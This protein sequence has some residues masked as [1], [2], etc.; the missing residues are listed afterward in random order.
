MN[1]ELL[2]PQPK[3]T[4]SSS[5]Q[6][7]ST[8][9]NDTEEQDTSVDRIYDFSD[10]DIKPVKDAD[11]PITHNVNIQIAEALRNPA[12]T[13]QKITQQNIEEESDKSVSAQTQRQPISPPE[14]I[15]NISTI[16]NQTHL[17]PVTNISQAINSNNDNSIT[18]KQPINKLEEAPSKP[19]PHQKID[20][21]MQAPAVKVYSQISHDSTTQ[22]QTIQANSVLKSE[23]IQSKAPLN[24]IKKQQPATE[25]KTPTSQPVVDTPIHDILKR[26]YNRAQKTTP[27][28]KDEMLDKNIG[29]F[30][31]TPFAPPISD[32]QTNALKTTPNIASVQSPISQTTARID[33]YREPINSETSP[34]GPNTINDPQNKTVNNKP[35][36]VPSNPKTKTIGNSLSD[37]TDTQFSLNTPHK[38]LQDALS[39]VLPT[40]ATSQGDKIEKT[41]Q[42]IYQQN[43]NKTGTSTILKPIRTFEG[44]VAE[45]MSHLHTSTA[46]VAIAENRRKSG[47]DRIDN[48]SSEK[49]TQPSNIFSKI[50]M[51]ITGILLIGGGAYVG[52]RFYI[53][54]PLA[55]TTQQPTQRQNDGII[56]SDSRAIIAIDG[57]IPIT[58][59]S[60]IIEEMDRE[61]APK[62]IK[63]II[64]AK[65]IGDSYIGITSSEALNVMDITAPDII[66]RTLTPEWMLG[67]YKN[68]DGQTD[69]FIIVNTT[70]F[71]NAFAGMLQWE[72]VITD[73]LKRFIKL[74]NPVIPTQPTSTSTQIDTITSSAGATSTATT[75]EIIEDTPSIQPTPVYSTIIRGSF[76]DRIVKNKDVRAFKTNSGETLFLYSF[77]DNSHIVFAGN[78]G[79]LS[80][81]INRL[82]KRVF[83]R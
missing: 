71:Q 5:Q 16:Q 59:L 45:A 66:T 41:A 38:N 51:A 57:Q 79:T 2:T 26:A 31:V 23:P 33:A 43:H 62:S 28:P 21:R 15:P 40:K 81:I 10:G 19:I 61:Q 53:Q 8:S 52:Y 76:Q 13:V 46:S 49:S 78:E 44:D 69:P 4:N 82:E 83:I 80:E 1:D 72:Q 74:K 67:V 34:I 29:T 42:D 47:E 39:N 37:Y 77:I 6:D 14:P 55:P 20:P 35:E 64:L 65:K 58:I 17:Q 18:L 48:T 60:R 54:S 73:D 11:G 12:S 32:T 30:E 22:K 27:L 68:T 25:P 36:T 63:E 50:L 3:Q 70:F 56:D 9:P 7:M 75:T 24:N